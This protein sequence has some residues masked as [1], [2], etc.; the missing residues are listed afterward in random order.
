MGEGSSERAPQTTTTTPSWDE[1]GE[2]K[3]TDRLTMFSKDARHDVI[4]R[5]DDVEELVIRHVL[6]S[7]FALRCVARVGLAEDSVAIPRDD[8]ARV[9]GVPRKLGDRVCVDLLSLGL[10]LIQAV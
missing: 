8:L 3:Y 2:L 4:D 10:S 6:E 1:Q 7:K 5:G 9:E